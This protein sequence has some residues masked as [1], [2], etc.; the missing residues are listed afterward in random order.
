LHVGN[1]ADREGSGR[2]LTA[3]H[4]A[5]VHGLVSFAQRLSAL[6]AADTAA[7][8]LDFDGLTPSNVARC[9]GNVA[10]ADVIERLTNQR[11]LFDTSE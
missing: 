8:L 11:T 10:T 2:T 5:A 1:V 9:R 6:P 4:V 3:L 7:S